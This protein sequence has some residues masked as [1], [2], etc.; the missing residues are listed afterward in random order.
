MCFRQTFAAVKSYLASGG[1]AWVALP[2][3]THD[4]KG[5]MRKVPLSTDLLSHKFKNLQV[6]TTAVSSGPLKKIM[7]AGK[8]Q[9]ILKQVGGDA[10]WVARIRLYKGQ[11]VIHFMNTALLAVAHPTLKDLSGVLY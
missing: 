1:T 5:F 6:I 7:A 4:E 9:S 10:G 2:F 8:F 3:G 11:P